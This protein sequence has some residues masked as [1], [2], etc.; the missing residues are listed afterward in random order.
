M[1]AK[2]QGKS[3]NPASQKT[4]SGSGASGGQEWYSTHKTTTHNDVECCAQGAPRPQVSSTH[5]TA[6][7]GAQTFPGNTEK[8][9]VDNVDNDSG[10][11]LTF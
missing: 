7:M 9:A 10:K 8:K 5:T 11:S 2:G 4:K 6:A 3:K 1:S